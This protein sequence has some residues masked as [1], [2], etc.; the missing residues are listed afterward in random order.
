[1]TSNEKIVDEARERLERVRTREE[2][3]RANWKSNYRFGHGD[4]VNLFQWEGD[5]TIANRTSAGKPCFTINRTMHYCNQ[6]INDARQNKSEIQI[7]AVGNGA[8][9]DSATILEGIVRHIQ[10]ISNAEQAYE[11]ATYDQVFGGMGWWRVVTDYSSDDSF[12]QEIYIRRC[13][14]SLAVY[15]DD[16]IQQYDGSDARFGFVMTDMDKGEFQK[17]Y[18]RHK[19]IGTATAPLGVDD[20]D[21]D[22]LERAARVRLVEYYRKVTK[23]DTLHY[24]DS[25][26][27]I[28]ES[29]VEAEIMEDLKAHSTDTRDIESSEIE[30][31]LIAGDKIIEKNVWPGKFIPLVRVPGVVTDI[32]GQ[33]NWA[34]HVT[35]LRD[36][37]RSLNYYVSAGI[38]FVANQTKSPWMADVRS[39]EG[40][41]EY[42]QQSN[43]RN[44]SILPFKSV[45]DDGTEIAPQALPHRADPPIYAPAFMDGMKVSIEEM[46]ITSGQPPAVMGEESNERSGKAIQERQRAASNSTYH[47]VNNLANALRFTGKILIDLVP[48][49]YDTPRIMKILGQDGT[50]YTVALDPNAPDAHKQLQGLDDES[51]DPQQIAA[52]FNP[53]VG[54]YDVVA[55]VGPQYTTRREQFV[56]ATMDIM[57]QNEQLAPYIGD[58]VFAN[59]DFPGAKLIAKRMR[60]VVAA[61]HPEALGTVDPQVQNLQKQLGMQ[62]QMMQQMQGELQQAKAKESVQELQKEIDWYKAE[63]DRLKA[64][65]A[66]DPAAL[67]PVVRQLVSELLGTPVNPIIA[68]HVRENAAML[69][70]PE[71]PGPTQ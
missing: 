69:P 28:R 56:A 43:I 15:L 14:Q 47:F 1:M 29:D 52:I 59:M 4:S 46:E 3:A 53:T 60:N 54:E 11:K 5:D 61:T 9:Y 49:I 10:Y 19:D 24:L 12:D 71:Q 62:N 32:D 37:Q 68:A 36:A 66:I 67:M 7:R 30:H 27:T 48:K 23:T 44:F 55:E 21:G 34:G 2:A 26:Q 6:I 31:Y 25:G 17:R 8:T 41:E 13:P 65:G 40:L 38:E 35:G 33:L 16:A 42:W 18:P 50:Q 57:A 22:D 45:G 70:Q 20:Y 39:I 64:V 51:F 63:T 58:L